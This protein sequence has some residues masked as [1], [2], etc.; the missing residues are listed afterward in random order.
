MSVEDN[1][2]TQVDTLLAVDLGGASEMDVFPGHNY[3]TFTVD[4]VSYDA[5]VRYRGGPHWGVVAA[6]LTEGDTMM[7]RYHGGFGDGSAKVLYIDSTNQIIYMKGTPGHMMISWSHLSYTDKDIFKREEVATTHI[8]GT[9]TRDIPS[10]YN[11]QTHKGN[12]RYILSHVSG[13]AITFGVGDVF[14][15]GF[16]TDFKVKIPQVLE[17]QDQDGNPA[18]FANSDITITEALPLVSTP[19]LDS[20]T[21]T[22]TS[23]SSGAHHY[24]PDVDPTGLSFG[25]TV[26]LYGKKLTG[27]EVRIPMEVTGT[28]SL[29]LTTSGFTS[30]FNIPATYTLTDVEV[31]KFSVT[32]AVGEFPATYTFEQT[33]TAGEYEIVHVDGAVLDWGGLNDLYEQGFN[34][35]LVVVNTTTASTIPD[36]KKDAIQMTGTVIDANVTAPIVHFDVN[37]PEGIY[38]FTDLEGTR[39]SLVQTFAGTFGQPI[40]FEQEISSRDATYIRYDF[41]VPNYF[42]DGT[43][44]LYALKEVEFN[45]E[46]VHL[47]QS[48]HL[49]WE[50]NYSRS[51]DLA[52]A[53]NRTHFPNGPG[54][55]YLNGGIDEHGH[56]K[57][58]AHGRNQQNKGGF[59]QMDIEFLPALDGSSMTAHFEPP[60]TRI[61][62]GHE[63]IEITELI[64]TPVTAGLDPLEINFPHAVINAHMLSLDDTP[65]YYYH[66]EIEYELVP[67]MHMIVI[68]DL[69]DN[70]REY[71]LKV[72]IPWTADILDYEVEIGFLNE[73]ESNILNVPFGSGQGRIEKEGDWGDILNEDGHGY[74]ITEG[75]AE[76]YLLDPVE[77]E[78]ELYIV[79]QVNVAI[80]DFEL[81]SEFY[82]SQLPF[83]VHSEEIEI[84]FK[85][86]P[87]VN[88]LFGDKD[89]DRIAWNSE[90]GA[91]YLCTEDGLHDL[92][93]EGLPRT[94]LADPLEKEREL[95][96][97]Y[98]SFTPPTPQNLA[99]E[100]GTGYLY[101]DGGYVWSEGDYTPHNPWGFGVNPWRVIIEEGETRTELDLA[102]LT[103]NLLPTIID[104]EHSVEFDWRQI[105]A[106]PMGDIIV[107]NHNRDREDYIDYRISDLIMENEPGHILGEDGIG[108]AVID[109]GPDYFF[110]IANTDLP[111]LYHRQI[112][113]ELDVQTPI[114]VAAQ[115]EMVHFF[116]SRIW[117]LPP[118]AYIDWSPEG[119]FGGFPCMVDED[120]VYR[121]VDENYETGLPPYEIGRICFEPAT[122]PPDD[123]EWHQVEIELIANTQPVFP[124]PALPPLLEEIFLGPPTII[125]DNEIEPYPFINFQ[126]IGLPNVRTETVE[127][128]ERFNQILYEGATFVFEPI[129]LEKTLLN[130]YN[131]TIVNDSDP[132]RDRLLHVNIDAT[133]S[134]TFDP[135]DNELTP[136]LDY[137]NGTI[138]WRVKSQEELE[139]SY[140]QSMQP[141]SVAT[142]LEH[143]NPFP[144]PIFV[145]VPLDQTLQV[146]GQDNQMVLAPAMAPLVKPNNDFVEM[147]Y[148]LP[149]NFIGSGSGITIISD[150]KEERPIELLPIVLDESIILSSIDVDPEY[151]IVEIV[152]LGVNDEAR[153]PDF[154]RFLDNLTTEDD[155]NI[156]AEDGE[157]LFAD[158]V[159]DFG[160][161][162]EFA[163]VELEKTHFFTAQVQNA[164]SVFGDTELPEVK[165]FVDEL[166][167]GPVIRPAEFSFEGGTLVDTI[168]VLATFSVF[169]GHTN[170]T[171][172]TFD[173]LE[174]FPNPQP[175]LDTV[176]TAVTDLGDIRTQYEI[177]IPAYDVGQSEVEHFFLSS[178]A[179]VDLF[180]EDDQEIEFP[181]TIAT[182]G[183]LILSDVTQSHISG[184]STIHEII[185][186]PINSAP[187]MAPVFSEDRN[188]DLVI[189]PSVQASS[190]MDDLFSVTSTPNVTVTEDFDVP[191][192]FT[193]NVSH[194]TTGVS[195]VFG[196]S[197][198][199]GLV[200]MGINSLGR[201]VI[202]NQDGD[203]LI[204]Q[205]AVT[206]LATQDH[207]LTQQDVI[208]DDDGNIISV[209]IGDD[210]TAEAITHEDE[211]RIILNQPFV[212]GSSEII[213]DSISSP[214]TVDDIVF[215]PF[216]NYRYQ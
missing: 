130:V 22:L 135:V 199:S 83:S 82:T 96:I 190:F 61:V 133:I 131:I 165:L 10:V 187:T 117:V 98:N 134:S 163:T 108:F 132:F 92:V 95:T 142:I 186:G 114:T 119:S 16:V 17:V 43:I 73:Y 40:Y 146:E 6:G 115:K 49:D 76:N 138:I 161:I 14:D 183:Q 38:Y 211:G 51:I 106:I 27:E 13:P 121:I 169:G 50:N 192:E 23:N 68:D 91:G 67:D 129:E 45:L 123:Q 128:D 71:E 74:F 184:Y 209:D 185:L 176:A 126:P 64:T 191:R 174:R 193:T 216:I 4:G 21:M 160:W 47:W 69:A 101:E 182:A 104:D 46:T 203:Y 109:R 66:R 194:S 206:L 145:G 9:A 28:S 107:Y 170:T 44:Q 125:F 72:Q 141:I 102:P 205:N 59:T 155:F 120:G 33:G 26:W 24:F 42:L 158:M 118:E 94:V 79:Q 157:N 162:E 173:T 31:Q 81:D 32:N 77:I 212:P 105:D 56:W 54:T 87:A 180:T 189:T 177:L 75:G 97:R 196:R 140:F 111:N 188:L 197:I 201:I 149:I 175:S 143:V 137:Q 58:F 70:E 84:E 86:P 99:L 153:P 63:A 18:T 15:Q 168:N 48:D 213:L 122:F 214:R 124:P 100:D 89:L 181:N 29:T 116:E 65:E 55:N 198:S 172:N 35:P 30:D 164:F 150:F 103:A 60:K 154:G 147:E 57:A 41:M 166:S 39:P 37:L 20:A 36:W 34:T 148:Q 127:L 25:D 208:A 195:E 171:A 144:Q 12:G 202:A 62:H 215:L 52:P 156:L 3:G 207:T 2:F 210:V 152:N 8:T 80:F 93:Y 90:A 204:T 110:Y 53:G 200:G 178:E 139:Q 159:F 1:T 11:F 167:G 7:A 88:V 151:D 136:V 5:D 112:E 113:I 78:Y 85:H 19:K 179:D